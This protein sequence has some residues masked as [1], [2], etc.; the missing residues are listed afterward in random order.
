[1]ALWRTRCQPQILL[2]LASEMRRSSLNWKNKVSAGLDGRKLQGNKP[3]LVPASNGSNIRKS[4]SASDVLVGPFG[5]NYWGFRGIWP[6]CRDI[7]V[8]AW[9]GPEY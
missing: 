5:M 4:A 3:G 6:V 9:G 2:S 7:V 1:V 8:W